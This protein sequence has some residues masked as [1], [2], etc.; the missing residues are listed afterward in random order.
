MAM[1]KN[2]INSIF[3]NINSKS[4]LQK[5][6]VVYTG[7]NM[8]LLTFLTQIWLKGRN[9]TEGLIFH[10]HTLVTKSNMIDMGNLSSYFEYCL[11]K[12]ICC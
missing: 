3:F 4:E 10:E 1:H 12:Y 6:L 5:Y 11:S 2:L 9:Y 8:S 7:F